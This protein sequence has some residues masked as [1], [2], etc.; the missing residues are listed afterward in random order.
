MPPKTKA[1]DTALGGLR[2]PFVTG[3]GGAFPNR[4]TNGRKFR[5]AC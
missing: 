1:A 5:A 2:P 4:F 3:P